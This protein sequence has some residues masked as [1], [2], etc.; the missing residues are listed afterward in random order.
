VIVLRSRYTGWLL[1]V[2][3]IAGAVATAAGSFVYGSAELRSRNAHLAD[4]ASF[5]VEAALS[6]KSFYLQD[7]AD[8][9]G[10]HDD[11]DTEEFSRYARVRNG[12][13]PS[14][15]LVRWLRRSPSGRLLPPYEAG[16]RPILLERVAGPRLERAEHKAAGAG[17]PVVEG[18][19]TSRQPVVSAPISLGRIN[20][21]LV[22]VPV[23]PHHDSGLLSKF[24]S[25]SVV[26]GLLDADQLVQSAL[27]RAGI[28]ASVA[29]SDGGRLLRRDHG[30]NWTQ[31]DF[32]FGQRQWRVFVEPLRQSALVSM[33]PW[34]ILAAGALLGTALAVLLRTLQSR[35]ARAFQL[36]DRR[37]AEL[38]QSLA[39]TKRI[40]DAI[41]ERFYT[42]ELLPDGG[43][44][45]LLMT[46]G[47]TLGE[48]S[49][50]IEDWER[51]VHPDD[52][53]VWRQAADAIQNGRPVDFEF[54]LSTVDD[55]RWIWARERPLGIVDGRRLIDGVASDVT[56]RKRAEIALAMAVGD[57]QTANQELVEAHA[58]AD[59]RSR[60]D[61]LTGA[62]NRRHFTGLL[63]GLLNQDQAPAGQLAVLLVDIDHFKSINDQHGHQAGDVVLREITRRISMA[64]HPA[65]RLARWGGDEFVILGSEA[66]TTSALIAKAQAVIAAVGVEPIGFDGKFL[67]VTAS[68]GVG[69]VPTDR[70]TPEEVVSTVDAALYE[71]KRL[72]R[73]R[74][75]AAAQPRALQAVA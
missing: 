4:R 27:G 57:M 63:E 48:E 22:A 14:V 42:Y 60:T 68:V 26:V 58:E 38:A 9:V 20:G 6:H 59:R 17:S 43:R 2:A 21:L 15:L 54:R 74:V 47:W 7:V 69:L 66:T 18:A 13:D 28:K 29:V 49:E 24:E 8:M 64:I 62:F 61:M 35:G 37:G 12:N 40:A 46:A 73:N 71:A 11:A 33:L 16:P 31:R 45:T 75:A 3:V 67:H 34:L 53:D 65:D 51:H 1:V 72:G 25:E 36:A 44:R 10:V 5:A 32:L 39:M 41:E 50:T 56:K 70:R 19:N 23:R 52:R 30:T 55:E